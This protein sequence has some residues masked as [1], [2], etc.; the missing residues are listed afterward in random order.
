MTLQK[1]I[2]LDTGQGTVVQSRIKKGFSFFL[3]KKYQT[4]YKTIKK[5]RNK[6]KKTISK[7]DIAI[8]VGYQIPH[9]TF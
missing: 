5:N 8:H 6:Y 1:F 9:V 7:P 2:N 4:N 3:K